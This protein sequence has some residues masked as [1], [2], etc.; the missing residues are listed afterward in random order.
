MRKLRL[1]EFKELAHSWTINMW[2]MRDLKPGL[3]NAKAHVFSVKTGYLLKIQF[4]LFPAI[5]AFLS[6]SLSLGLYIRDKIKIGLYLIRLYPETVS[7][8]HK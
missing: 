6:M 8:V 7:L 3:F 2:H 4:I 5:A 1:R